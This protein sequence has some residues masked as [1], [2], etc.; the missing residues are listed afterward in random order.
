MNRIIGFILTALVCLSFSAFAQTNSTLR[1]QVVDEVGAVI[2]GAK[3]TIV[4]PNGRQRSVT[5]NA[6][7][8][9]S[10]PNVTPGNYTFYVEFNGFQ[11]F[12]KTDLTVPFNDQLKVTMMVASVTVETEVKSDAGGVSVEPDQN[13]NATVLDEEF[14]KTLPDNEDDLRDYLQALA[15]PAAG[16]ASGGQSGGAQILVNGFSGGRLPPREAIQQIRIN[17]NPFSAEYSRP[18]FGRIEIITKPGLDS[19]RGNFATNFRSSLLDARNAFAKE[20]PDSHQETFFFN[21]GGPII[22]KKMSAFFNGSRRQFSGENNVYARTLDGDFFANVKAP[23]YST[24]FNARADYLLT[25]KNTLNVNYQFFSSNSK[26]SEFATRFGG[27]FFI[28]GGGGGG[29][30]FGGGGG[31]GGTSVLLPE[32]A[33]NRDNMNHNIQISDMH[34]ISS[35]LVHESRLQL[36]RET[37]DVTAVTQGIAVNVIDAFSGGGSTCCPNNSRGWQADFQDYLSY[38]YKKHSIKGGFQIQYENSRDYSASNFNGTYTFSSLDQYRAALDVTNPNR[39]AAQFSINLGNPLLTYSQSEMAWFIQDDWRINQAFTL[40]LGLRH[41][42]QTNL[43]DKNNFAPRLGI[44]WSPFKDRKTTIRGG[45]GIFYNRFNTGLLSTILRN[46]GVIQQSYVIPFPQFRTQVVNGVVVPIAP[47]LT[48]VAPSSQTIRTAD[49]NLKAPYVINF[50]AAVERQL[51]KGLIGSVSYIYTRGVHQFRARNINAPDANGQRPNPTKPN[52]FQLESTANSVYNGFQFG[53]QRRMGQRFIVF[54]NYT[55]S[56]TKN[57]SDGSFSTPADNNN[58]ASEWGRANSDRRHYAFIGGSITLPKG[59]RLMPNI[60]AGSGSPF[61]IT[62][63]Q[64]LNRDTVFNDRP[65]GVN[66][67]SDLPASLYSNITDTRIRTF[68][69]TYYPS[70]VKAIGPG[71]FNVN[72]SLSKTFTFG[73][74]KATSA[75][76]TNGRGGGRGPGGGG[77]GGGGGRGPGGGGFGG[78]GGG[79]GGGGFGG[80]GGGGGGPFI[81]GGPGNETGRYSLTFTVQAT[82]V[83]NRV[84]YGQYIGSL[85]SSL[86]GRP[87]SA[88]PARQLEMSI[89]FGF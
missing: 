66:R 68:L 47:D 25:P 67:N 62:L 83:I 27:G 60:I 24:N 42:F 84:N 88:S 75:D 82:N 23:S 77:F 26:N 44:A 13:L 63:G 3:A 28:G 1:G 11:T 70:G 65:R 57:D 48:N 14:I 34:I 38:T 30:G 20:R 4:M 12:V 53:L 22:K 81:V 2:P 55:L 58:L 5:T 36:Q 43:S 87:V 21:I 39:T 46:D 31:G 40:S 33:S 89:R 72:L 17:Q 41:E 15:G 35:R 80:P 69:E 9:F 74:P 64:D 86:F 7:G 49:S 10:I 16:G 18:G 8:E 76:A 79:P 59:L 61:N 71:L 73:K 51:P 56:W 45:A 50:N 85:S 52:I 6:N 54:G 32:R 78:P 29:F 37:S 19:W